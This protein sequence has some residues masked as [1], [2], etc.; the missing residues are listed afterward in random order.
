MR[1]RVSGAR[2]QLEGNW[3][4]T[5]VKLGRIDILSGALQQLEMGDTRTLQIDCQHITAIDMIGEELLE[6]WFQC[7][8]HRGFEPILIALPD[9]LRQSIRRLWLR[10]GKM[11]ASRNYGF[12]DH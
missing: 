7:A 4:V 1:L 5:G 3:T 12:A 11:D 8:Q 9:K 2:I 10:Y 6:A